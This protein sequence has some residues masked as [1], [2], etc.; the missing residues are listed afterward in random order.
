[1]ERYRT[2][3]V[4]N[5]SWK[6]MWLKHKKTLVEGAAPLA[7]VRANWT[8]SSKAM[9]NKDISWKSKVSYLYPTSLQA[10]RFAS[11]AVQ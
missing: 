9:A 2:G 5:H 10:G 3:T 4:L 1:M 6:T 8:K 11:H 7:Q